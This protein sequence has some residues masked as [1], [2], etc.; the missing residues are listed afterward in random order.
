MR[1]ANAR[2]LHAGGPPT[3][4]STPLGVI[5]LKYI[6]TKTFLIPRC[7]N[8]TQS[9]TVLTWIKITEFLECKFPTLYKGNMKRF[10]AI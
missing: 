6:I 8:K 9:G 10:Y 7:V 3:G 1:A 4:K 5:R 2:T